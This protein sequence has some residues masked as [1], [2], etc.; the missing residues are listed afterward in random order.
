[1]KI[2]N[3]YKTKEGY[4]QLA[5]ES[6]AEAY[7]T[8]LVDNKSSIDVPVALGSLNDN[9]YAKRNYDISI[10]DAPLDAL[11]TIWDDIDFFYNHQKG[12]W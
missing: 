4:Y 2:L 5:R 3:S 9:T 6:L 8:L 1:M 7:K 12:N 11:N 10:K